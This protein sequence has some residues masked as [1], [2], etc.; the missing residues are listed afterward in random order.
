MLHLVNSTKDLHIDEST[1]AKT[2]DHE[3]LLESYLKSHKIRNHSPK[4]FE[5]EQA[6]LRGWFISHG[7]ENKPLFTWEAMKPIEGRKLISDY[8]YAL[9]EA[10]LASETI[11][12]YVGIL[13][14]YFAYVLEHAFVASTD[15]VRHIPSLYG[16][17]DQPV[18]EYDMPK[19]VYDGEKEG[20][21]MDPERIYQ[22]YDILRKEYLGRPGAQQAVSARNYTAVVVAGECGLRIDELIHLDI[23]YDLFFDSKKL[24]TRFGKGTQG[25]GKRP[26]TTLFPPLA[27]DTVS[28]FLKEHHSKISK[29]SKSNHLFPSNRGQM[30]TYSSFHEA[31]EEMLRIVRKANFHVAPNMTWHWFRRIF[32]TRFIEKFPER[33]DVLISLLGHTSP[34]TV[35][36]YIR[37]SEAWMDKQ[38]QSVIEGE[39]IIW[40]SSGD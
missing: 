34:N 30:M 2:R 12:S 26:R 40:Q 27:R 6:F 32:A 29:E 20:I 4:T 31:L 24:Q 35:H 16:P 21:P 25:S 1:A 19:H 3:R 10:G 39:S 17:I 33:M 38:I 8:A 11:R 28:Y 5:R 15:G 18:S 22:F 23:R 36:R 9:V 37:H 7:E 13:S 14:R